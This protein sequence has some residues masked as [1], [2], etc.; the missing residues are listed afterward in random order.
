MTYDTPFQQKPDS[1]SLKATLSKAKD[2]SPD[3]WGDIHINMNDMTAVKVENG[4]T[5]FKL[6][7]WKRIDRNGKTYLSLSVN[8]WVP[9]EQQATP[10][11]HDFPDEDLPF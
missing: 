6:S 1:G 3:Y 2:V 11:E 8:R 9:Q 4:L 5:V 10:E 7:G